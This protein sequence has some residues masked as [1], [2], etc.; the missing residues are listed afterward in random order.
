M[1]LRNGIVTLTTDFGGH[2]AY[3]GAMKG[4]VCRILPTVRLVD[5][6]HEIPPQNVSE[7]AQLLEAAYPWFPAGTVHLAVVDPGVG[8]RRRALAV[9]AA[10]H[11]FVGP[12]NGV[13]S[14][15]LRE[16]G[17]QAYE[18]IPGPHGLPERSDTFH[19]RDVFAPAAGHLAAGLELERLGPRAHDCLVLD[20]PRPRVG[21][22]F[23]A[24]EV[25][26]IDHFG[27]ALTNIPRS[28]LAAL[29]GGPCEVFVGGASYGR[30]CRCYQDVPV[31]GALALTG[32]DGRIEIAV[33]GGSAAERCRI[34]P[35][36][37]VE[38]R[39]SPRST[40]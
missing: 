28:L 18:I 38:V 19:G 22:G 20:V 26:R 13:L 24:G 1:A 16:P 37:R 39:P 12:D 23:V 36:D 30:L 3:V 8:T 25:A 32:G 11:C 34:A 31:G 40:R 4:V 9:A 7:A 14:A 17:A 21:K 10:G 15:P 2:D 5:I 35:G 33:N 27:N 6:T 29:G